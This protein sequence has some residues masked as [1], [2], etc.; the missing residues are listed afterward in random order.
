[1]LKVLPSGCNIVVLKMHSF[2]PAQSNNCEYPS[3]PLVMMLNFSTLNA[4]SVV[5]GSLVE[6]NVY[7]TSD[8]N[9]SDV[10]IKVDL[11]GI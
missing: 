1:M 9:A 5:A 10:K 4:S 6:I 7:F 11:E 2:V 3:L 8:V